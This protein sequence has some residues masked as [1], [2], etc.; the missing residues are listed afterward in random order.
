MITFT[1]AKI[2]NGFLVGADMGY[3][4]NSKG[5]YVDDFKVYAPTIADAFAIIA[6]K[7]DS[8]MED[9]VD[10]PPEVQDDQQ[11]EFKF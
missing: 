9:E 7:C 8:F 1:I 6:N 2:D 10:R 11:D 5:E 4:E 3:Y